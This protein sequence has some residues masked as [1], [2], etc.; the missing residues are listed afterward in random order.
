MQEWKD[1]RGAS[2]ERSINVDQTLSDDIMVFCYK[3]FLDKPNI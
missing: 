1:A 3:Y 2:N